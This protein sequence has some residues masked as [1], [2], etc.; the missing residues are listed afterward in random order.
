MTCTTCQSPN[1]D[2]ARFCSTCGTPLEA[3]RPVEG[4]RKRVAVLFADVVGSTGMAEQLDPEEVVDLM[5]GAFAFM[6]AA[7]T[8]YEG[9][10]ARLMGDAVLA[11]FGA[12]VAHEDDPE[13]AVRAGLEIR[14]AARAYGERVERRYGVPFAVRVGIHTGLAVA[15]EVGSAFSTEYTAMGDTPNLASRLQTA[16]RPGTVLISDATYRHVRH[17]VEVESAGLLE[18]RG[19]ARPV[20]TYEVTAVKPEPTT[21]RGLDGVHSRL[22]GRDAE[23]AALREL[24]EAVARREGGFVAVLGEAGLGK[25]RLV[26]EVREGLGEGDVRWL[27]G[28]GL[29]Y[30]QGLAYHP[31][32][33]ALRQALGVTEH[34][35][36]ERARGRLRKGLATLGRPEA[37][38][39]FLE[40]VLAVESEESLRA[41]AALDGEAIVERLAEAVC[42]ALRALAAQAP[43]VLVFDDFH[44]ADPASVDLL[45]RVAEG[46]AGE[47]I[48]LVCM[49]RPDKAAPS[50][51]MLARV[52]QSAAR[53]HELALGPLDAGNT[54]ELLGNLLPIEGLPEP[55]R[56]A[57]LAK[58]EGNPFFL[59]EVLRALIDSGHI[60]HEGGRWRATQE[61]AEVAIPDTLSG[62]LSARIDRLPEPTKRVAQT[63]AVL[64]RIFA[65]E[66]LADVCRL[67]PPPER[68]PHVGPHLATLAYEELVRERTLQPVLE[69][70]FKHALTQEAAY[71][72]LLVRKRKELH[73]RAGEALERFHAERG[74]E[75]APVVARHYWMGEAWE[76]AARHARRAGARARQLYALDDALAHF[77]QA[78]DALNRL[79]NAAP[80]DRIDAALEWSGTAIAL[81]R[82]EEEEPR[83]ELLRRLDQAL[84][85]ARALGDQR[86][87]ARVLVEKGSVLTLSGRPGSAFPYLIEA[88]DL[89]S[90][91]GDDHLFLL[92]F[93]TTT[94]H[95]VDL[96]P[97][98][99]VG[100]LRE[101][102]ALAQKHR[103][104][105]IEAHATA[106]L[107]S[108]HAR[109]GEGE[110]AREAIARALELA[111]QSRS[112]IKEA[113]VHIVVAGVYYDLGEVERGIEHAELGAELA[114]SVNGIECASAGYAFAGIGN[115]HAD[116]PRAAIKA[117]GQALDVGGEADM[118]ALL[119]QIRA[120]KAIAHYHDGDPAALGRIEA[121]LDN[122][123]R[124]GDSFGAAFM[125][126]ALADAHLGRGELDRAEAYLSEALAYYREHGMRPYVARTLDAL[127]PLRERQGRPA[128]A[129]E[130]RAEAAALRAPALGDPSAPVPA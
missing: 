107:A 113:D 55:I 68:V 66:V 61:I 101:V 48:L 128:E 76:H 8:R 129:A 18:V 95:L 35:P 59:E 41:L 122:A 118:G 94:E 47:P 96:D 54:R 97:R 60:V 32:R 106:V 45:G 108:A 24:V 114:H 34:D 70:I 39:P 82:P 81:R 73:R 29:S 19:R 7:V 104:R 15:G 3:A 99:A 119:N 126:K 130:A 109:L 71:D 74:D 11:V 27:E 6:T 53:Y 22:V 20:E 89:A 91:L 90:A 67:A 56:D 92:P 17:T 111:P 124:L 93:F 9:T 16:A 21:A 88:S 33:Q 58:A 36:P 123:L 125:R 115:L 78:L 86:R 102:I 51:R 117:L 2:S 57:I 116:R 69:Y 50:W 80:E 1:A 85:A 14:D 98:R 105:G 43:T 100:Q 63:A 31:W 44:W 72:L 84:E 52:R 37:D 77:E 112:A 65:H 120:W 30:G 38:L 26:A 75:M 4:E 46:A 12:P 62:V 110:A 103:D 64:G 83:E 40:A 23:L 13:R 79:P 10:V 49:L 25:S 5:N 127:A 87:I 42:G 121:A 28:R